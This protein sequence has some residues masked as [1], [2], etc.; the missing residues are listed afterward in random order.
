MLKTRTFRLATLLMVSSLALPALAQTPLPSQ[1]QPPPVPLPAPQPAPVD[2]S[3]SWENSL[4][5]VAALLRTAR[6]RQTNA[7]KESA[8]AYV[9]AE[10]SFSRLLSLAGKNNLKED[11]TIKPLNGFNFADS[12]A[13]V[14]RLRQLIAMETDQQAATVQWQII[15]LYAKGVKSL[16]DGEVEGALRNPMAAA[17]VTPAPL[18][19]VEPPVEAPPPTTPPPTEPPPTTPPPPA[20]SFASVY[21]PLFA[22]RT[23]YKSVSLA[24]PSQISFWL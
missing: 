3:G 8:S 1:Q 23:T 20:V 5:K 9:A 11:T 24:V 13:E 10:Q 19:P 21:Q 6:E 17:P 4:R 12:V 7:D 14:T 22:A 2:I 18:P 16:F 15:T